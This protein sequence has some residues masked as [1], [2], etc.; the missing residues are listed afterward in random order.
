MNYERQGAVKILVDP[1]PSTYT[2]TIVHVIT[3]FGSQQKS[4]LAGTSRLR[5]LTPP[6]RVKSW[7]RFFLCHFPTPIRN[8][9]NCTHKQICGKQRNKKHENMKPSI[10]Q[11]IKKTLFIF[12]YFVIHSVFDLLSVQFS[13]I[14]RPSLTLRVKTN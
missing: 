8:W 12:A 2:H 10:T 7:L 11:K 5:A 4:F 1:A 3:I 13:R 14:N 6:P 9:Q